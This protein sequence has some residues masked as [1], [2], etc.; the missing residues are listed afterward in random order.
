VAVAGMPELDDAEVAIMLVDPY[1]F[2]AE[3]LL[4]QLA[5]D[6]PGLPVMGGLASAG[7]GPGAGVL[8]CDGRYASPARWG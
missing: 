5:E 4:D 6:F 3:P 2:P 8:M 7:G 1:S